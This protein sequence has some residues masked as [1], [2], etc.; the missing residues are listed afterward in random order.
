MLQADLATLDRI[1]YEVDRIAEISP[2]EIFH[3]EMSVITFGSRVGFSGTADRME[4][5]PVGQNTIGI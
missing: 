5:F 1:K 4:L 2:F 3:S